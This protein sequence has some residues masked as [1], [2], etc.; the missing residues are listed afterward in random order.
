M[1]NPYLQIL[2]ARARTD[3]LY[4]EAAAARREH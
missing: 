1:T 4:A 3:D 2:L